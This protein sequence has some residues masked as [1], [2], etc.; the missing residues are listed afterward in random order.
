M[1]H[2]YVKA[3]TGNDQKSRVQSFLERSSLTPEQAAEIMAHRN[4]PGFRPD[5]VRSIREQLKAVGF[6][7][8]ELNV[9]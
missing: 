3:A 2:H 4:V 6:N 8:L 1:R 9:H 5:Q 7:A